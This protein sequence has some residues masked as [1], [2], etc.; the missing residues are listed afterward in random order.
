VR[1]SR[2]RLPM[3]DESCSPVSAGAAEGHSVVWREVGTLRHLVTLDL[4]GE[5]ARVYPGRAGRRR[6]RGITCR[7]GPVG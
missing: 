5:T 3:D 4:M 2:N 6:L 1:F 7:Q